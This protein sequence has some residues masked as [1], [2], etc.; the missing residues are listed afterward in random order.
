V[1]FRATLGPSA[2]PFFSRKKK[3]EKKK[4]K[5]KY[6]VFQLGKILIEMGPTVALETSA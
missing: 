3:K 6:S 2:F 5:G 1:S 4:K